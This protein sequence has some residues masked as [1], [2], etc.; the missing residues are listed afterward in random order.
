MEDLDVECWV[1][2][3]RKCGGE[4]SGEVVEKCVIWDLVF[5]GGDSVY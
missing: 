1:S 4:W 2:R 5:L 3:G